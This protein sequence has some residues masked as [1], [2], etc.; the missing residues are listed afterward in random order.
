MKL[1][2]KNKQTVVLNEQY[3]VAESEHIDFNQLWEKDRQLENM[4]KALAELQE[5]QRV[6]ITL[7][8]LQKQSYQQITASTGF[9]LLQVKSHIQNGKRNLKNHLERLKPHD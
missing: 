6:C 9:S 1:R 7:F 2:D 8:Y 4:K 5:P 3:A